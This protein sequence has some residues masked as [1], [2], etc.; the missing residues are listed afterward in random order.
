MSIEVFVASEMDPEHR[1]MGLTPGLWYFWIE[2]YRRALG[3]YKRYDQAELHY[4]QYKLEK[5]QPTNA[6][7]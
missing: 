6:N 3:G 4:Q 5:R 2:N 7:G 1:S